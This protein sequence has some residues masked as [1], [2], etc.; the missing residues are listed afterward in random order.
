MEQLQ[1]NIPDWKVRQIRRTEKPLPAM[2][3][4]AAQD[5]LARMHKRH[6]S[7]RWQLWLSMKEIERLMVRLQMGNPNQPPAFLPGSRNK[8]T[9]YRVSQELFSTQEEKH[10][11]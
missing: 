11:A 3:Y 9:K 10:A 8:K 7:V 1:I 6:D 5:L 4:A 2:T